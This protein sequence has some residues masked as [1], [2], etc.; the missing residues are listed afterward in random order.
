MSVIPFHPRRLIAAAALA[1][2]AA[3]PAAAEGLD[4]VAVTWR[5]SADN[6]I[7]DGLRLREF[8]HASQLR[9]EP[10]D[11]DHAALTHRM[12]WGSAHRVEPGGGTV[13]LLWGQT[14]DYAIGFQVDDPDERGYDLSFDTLMRGYL[15][16]VWHGNSGT[17]ISMV[18]G[19]GTLMGATLDTAAGSLPLTA[20]A[21]PIDVV[22]ATDTEPMA[23]LLVEGT[24]H[25][26]AGHFV[27]SQYFTLNF[28]TVG[29]NVQAAFQNFN[30]GE[31]AARF[32]AELTSPGFA[33][34]GYPGPDGLPADAFGHFVRVQ[35]DYDVPPVPEPATA[36]LWAAGLAAMGGAARL[37]RRRAAAA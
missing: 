33:H 24:G 17:G 8:S 19:A 3:G 1:L 35:V 4:G 13:A 31:V 25:A 29:A 9:F 12:A 18:F 2:A 27:G 10:G 32:G 21:T 14:V 37:R 11:A 7:D 16:A 28:S 26:D 5:G 6:L 23:N 20:L 30:T 36:A 34:A 15:T 22:V